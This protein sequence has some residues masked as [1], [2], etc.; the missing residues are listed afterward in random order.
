MSLV[1]ID[2]SWEPVDGFSK[3]FQNY[4]FEIC[5]SLIH[6]EPSKVVEWNLHGNYIII[7]SVPDNMKK[8]M[9]L[10][11]CIKLFSVSLP[12]AAPTSFPRLR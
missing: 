9:L 3:L 7:M 4:F 12:S 2:I 10:C 5:L 11:M 8:V 6:W 1:P